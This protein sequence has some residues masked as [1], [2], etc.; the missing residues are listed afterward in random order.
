VAERLVGR[1]VRL[2]GLGWDKFDMIALGFATGQV[3]TI[4]QTI[5]AH[6]CVRLDTG[7]YGWVSDKSLFAVELMPEKRPVYIVTAFAPGDLEDLGGFD[8]HLDQREAAG[9]YER[10]VAQN[11]SAEI[12]FAEI[13]MVIDKDVIT[14]DD[15]L[16]VDAF[17]G[18]EL[19]DSIGAGLVGKIIKR[20]RP[21]LGQAEPPI[22]SIITAPFDD[23]EGDVAERMSD[24]YWLV[25]GE[26]AL[27]TWADL[28]GFT[29]APITILRHGY[30]DES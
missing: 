27:W 11:P 13:R 12:V 20:Y 19:Q 9:H 1:R 5:D 7:C 23:M 28:V 4:T 10:L 18:G 6:G 15:A 16:K 8:W 21:T 22:G 17:L 29:D 14:V 26:E 30:G 3:A 2:T 25:V 24:G